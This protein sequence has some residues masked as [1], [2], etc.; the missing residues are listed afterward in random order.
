VPVIIIIVGVL[1]LL[2]LMVVLK[3]NAFLA[4]IITALFVGVAE[5]MSLDQA[6]ASVEKGLGSTLGSLALVLGFGAM[7][8]KL[9]ADSGAAQR[10]AETLVTGF[11]KK[12]IQWAALLTA[13]I[14]GLAMFYETGFVILIPLVFSIALEAGVPILYIGIPV[15]AALITMHGLVP[16]H[17]G[18]VAIAQIFHAN[19]GITMLIGITIAIPAIV[20]GGI[21]YA[22]L[23]PRDSL[24]T[25]IPEA[26][27]KPTH[28]K[29][30]EMPSFGISIFT[31][32][33]PVLLMSI[34][35]FFEIVF[36]KSNLM[37]L[38]KFIGNPA[39]ALLISVLVAIFTFGLNRGKSI[40]SVM[41]SIAQSISSIAMILLI[42]GGGG[43]FKQVLVDSHVD[44]YIADLMGQTHLSPILLAWLLAAALRLSLGSATVA[45]MTAA[46]IVGP[47]IA[48]D[49]IS[50]EL[51][52]LAIGAGSITFS[53]VNDAGFWIYKEYYNLSIGQ[54]IKTWSVI[55]TIVS[56]VGLG[57]VL[58]W[59]T[60]L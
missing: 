14:V 56:V 22:R 48:L 32:I 30:D 24:N 50:P 40:K 39:I 10:I 29:D 5:G 37:F 47:L 20:I 27:F 31:A 7:L 46:G 19:L 4:L 52:V 49:H 6:I 3:I 42:I 25:E 35:A 59:Q 57:G 41:D 45:G 33:I 23:L 21:Y 15:T 53:H 38:F 11:G 28:F 26:L 18:P 51:M 58:V 9:L 13:F 43:G 1:L 36:P 16:P 2:L 8:G 60:I 44:K 54:T 55:T 12:H 34:Y 17:P